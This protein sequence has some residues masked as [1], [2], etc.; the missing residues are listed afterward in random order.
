MVSVL[1]S[2]SMD[3]FCKLS[4]VLVQLG[5]FTVGNTLSK[6][7]NFRSFMMA[8]ASKSTCQ[9]VQDLKEWKF[10]KLKLLELPIDDEK[11]NYV[12]RNNRGC[13]F[14]EVMPTPLKS[15]KLVSFSKDVLINILN[16]DPNVTKTQ[17]FADFIAGNKIMENSVPL[18]HRY[19]G[20]QFGYWAMQLG[21]GRAILLGEF[22]NSAGDRWE[23]QLKGSGSTPYSR[24]G[25]GRAVLRSSIRE[26]LCSE[27]MYYLG[28]PTSRAGAI[29]V[30]EERTLRDP[31]YD[32]NPVMENTAV[33]L[34]IAPTW[35]RF[36]SFELLMKTNELELP[37]KLFDFIIKIIMYN[38]M[39]LT[40]ALFP[41][42]TEI[43]KKQTSDLLQSEANYLTDSL[44]N[45]F[46]KKLGLPQSDKQLVEMFAEML[47]ETKADFTMSYRDLSEIELDQMD[48]P[49]PG[50]YWALA[51]VAQ[52]DA[53][54]RFV[55]AYKEKLKETGITDE[56]R[57]KQMCQI[58]PRYVLR[59]WMAQS[60]INEADDDNFVEV[61]RLLRI[62]SSPFTMQEEAEE[63]GFSKPPPGWASKLR[64]SCSS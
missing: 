46:S 25:D 9:L 37:K 48:K 4:L 49:C 36:G 51:T 58:N 18:A 61:E 64:L 11:N 42:L 21:D 5:L 23:L 59:N 6:K 12:R 45:T 17:D 24:D 60:A 1:L 50:Q 16:M 54:P 57:R 47:E 55:S 63:M 8:S 56:E 15:P 14:S 52:H 40:E 2:R 28:I 19:G 10:G 29:V 3:R 20:H 62:L 32:G 34:R 7:Y 44:I 30:S 31:M 27:A 33:V 38:L 26:F 22:T 39:K 13:L 43:Q 41:L 53:Y 35:F